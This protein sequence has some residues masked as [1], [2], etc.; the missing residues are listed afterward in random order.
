M[1]LFSLDKGYEK[2]RAELLESFLKLTDRDY[3]FKR[4]D[5]QLMKNPNPESVRKGLIVMTSLVEGVQNK[6]LKIELYQEI[7]RELVLLVCA[8]YEQ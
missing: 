1:R 6:D 4:F 5:S 8:G 7:I 2:E 3:L